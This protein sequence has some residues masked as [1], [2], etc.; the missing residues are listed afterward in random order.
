[1]KAGDKGKLRGTKLNRGI[2]WNGF[3]HKTGAKAGDVVTVS[4][5]CGDGTVRLQE[6]GT[7]YCFGHGDIEVIKEV[8]M[9]KPETQLE[10]NALAEAK[11]KAIEQEIGNKAVGYENAMKEYISLERQAQSYRKKADELAEKLGVTVA[12]KKELF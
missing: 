10:K 11:K 7:K 4:N 2:G 9:E 1:M 12:E 5:V 3:A 8:Q 6:F